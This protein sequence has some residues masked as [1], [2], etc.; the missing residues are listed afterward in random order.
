MSASQFVRRALAPGRP[1]RAVA[2]AA[3]LGAITLI[4]PA[5]LRAGELAAYRTTLAGITAADLATDLP[6]RTSPAA[7]AAIATLGAGAVLGLSPLGEAFDAKL[8]RSLARRGVRRPRVALAIAGAALVLASELPGILAKRRASRTGLGTSPG[9]GLGTDLS[10]GP[11]SALGIGPAGD[12]TTLGDLPDGARALI[13][14]M[15]EYSAEPSAGALAAQLGD[16]RELVWQGVPGS[17]DVINIDVSDAHAAPRAVP[18]EQRFPVTAE[19]RDPDSGTNR[20]VR[21]FVED[22]LLAR[23]TLEDGT[24]GDATRGNTAGRTHR[25]SAAGHW[26]GQWPSLAE[27]TFSLES[28]APSD[29]RAAILARL[30][31]RS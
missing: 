10:T 26:P 8:Q 31:S 21:L 20:L 17:Y 28:D 27:V 22:G 2:L 11:S 15:L 24:A 3:S 23:L 9:A 4:D 1:E 19:F 12:H 6:P 30:Q 29:R 14:G 16:A 5:K 18:H 13:A 7:R 25:A